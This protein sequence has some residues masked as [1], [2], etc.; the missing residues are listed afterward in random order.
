M[1]VDDVIKYSLQNG[2]QIDT[3]IEDKLS[4]CYQNGSCAKKYSKMYSFSGKNNLVWASFILFNNR[5]ELNQEY[6]LDIE[7]PEK[8]K[9]DKLP[10]WVYDKH[11]S[12]GTK[13][14][15][16]FFDNSLVVN[17]NIYEDMWGEGGDKYAE[18]CMAV[19]LED[20]K[21]LGNGKTN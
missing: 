5:P 6:S 8:R 15:Q 9:F 19:Y 12:G 21:N 7:L 2:L 17:E 11:V 1:V 16:F 13:G 10:S 20:E 3:K 18:E 14:Y 4:T